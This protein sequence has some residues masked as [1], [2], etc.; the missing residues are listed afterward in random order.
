MKTLIKKF[1]VILLSVFFLSIFL[2]YNIIIEKITN[3]IMGIQI[4]SMEQ[5]EELLKGKEQAPISANLTI[6]GKQTAYDKESNTIFIPQNL[7][8][9]YWEGKLRAESG[10]RLYLVED[11]LLK[12]KSSAISTGHVFQLYFVNE[13]SYYAYNLVFTGMPIMNIKLQSKDRPDAEI[14]VEGAL[15]IIDPYRF[16]DSIKN[17]PCTYSLRGASARGYE[18]SSY[19]LTLNNRKKIS[20]LGMREDD[21]WILNALYDD[22]GL[23]HNKLSFTV[24]REIAKNNNVKNDEGTTQEYAELFIDDEYLGV[25]GLTERIDAKELSLRDKDVLYKCRSTRIP[26]EHNYS[27]EMTDGMDPIFLLKYPKEYSDEDWNPLK[28]WVNLFC[29]DEIVSYQEGIQLLNMENAIDYNLFCLL[30]CGSD[31]M[32][33]NIYFIGEYQEDGTFSFKKVPWDLNATWGNP[34]IE[35]SKC[36]F[37]KYDPGA[38]EEV[39]VWCTDIDILY[40]YDEV[41][42]SSILLERWQELRKTVLTR[43]HLYEILDEQFGYLHLSGA[44]QRNYERWPHGAEYWQDDYIYQYIDGRLNFLDNYF[45]QLYLESL[46]PYMYM[47]I[48]YSE[49]FNTKYYWQTNKETLEELYPFDKELL[50]E[51]YV[52][53]GKPFGLEAKK[54]GT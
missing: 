27:N 9:D 48:D 33:K 14:G 49:E 22:S 38:I 35:D 13:S 42:V 7:N 46:E 16:E 17:I 8:K 34:W 28:E 3:R 2:N 39:D 29:K 12:A 32:R 40:Y 4:S 15:D 21:D 10:S 5:I 18:K 50:L 25:Y 36:N 30:I 54:A 41:E 11:D 44:Y 31:N 53:Y 6:Y 19:K 37:S 23:I 26:E 20:L 52:L 1:A 24:W 45:E 51:H 43:E 47:G